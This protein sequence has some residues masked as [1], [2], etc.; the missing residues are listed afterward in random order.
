MAYFV[1]R[2]EY[3]PCM[4]CGKE[5]CMG[6]EYDEDNNVVAECDCI[7]YANVH[8]CCFTCWDSLVEEQYAVEEDVIFCYTDAEEIYIPD[9][10]SE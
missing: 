7:G 5:K 2:V 1:D 6:A 8:A 3:H 4:W 9:S 10:E